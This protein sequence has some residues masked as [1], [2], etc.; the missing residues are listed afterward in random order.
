MMI[1]LRSFTLVDVLRQCR[2]A[3]VLAF[4]LFATDPDFAFA[5]LLMIILEM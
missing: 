5:R 3:V 1:W 2:R 4:T